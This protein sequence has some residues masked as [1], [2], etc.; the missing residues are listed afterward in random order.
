MT[1]VELVA[2]LHHD[3]QHRSALTCLSLGHEA[4]SPAEYH[5]VLHHSPHRGN[6]F[7]SGS[8]YTRE[9]LALQRCSSLGQKQ[10]AHNID[11]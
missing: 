5:H 10:H 11:P 3:D 1:S 8:I 2:S 6:F 4:H 9:R 7:P